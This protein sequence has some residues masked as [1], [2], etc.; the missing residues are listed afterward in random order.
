MHNFM[1]RKLVNILRNIYFFSSEYGYKQACKV[2]REL[3][4]K[5]FNGIFK[6]KRA[7]TPSNIVLTKLQ[8]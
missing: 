4:I 7:T 6:S 1:V 2:L 8:L 3:N 5:T